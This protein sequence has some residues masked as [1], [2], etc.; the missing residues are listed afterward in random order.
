MRF[1]KESG[2]KGPNYT[3]NSVYN[4]RA[5]SLKKKYLS[6]EYK[7]RLFSSDKVWKVNLCEMWTWN[8]IYRLWKWS[9]GGHS[10]GLMICWKHIET[11]LNPGGKKKNLLIMHVLL[12][13][14]IFT[15]DD[16][17]WKTKQTSM[18]SHV[19]PRTYEKDPLFIFE[20]FCFACLILLL[21][22]IIRGF[23]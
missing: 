13:G 20:L 11:S 15:S 2:I 23:M 16:T 14:V 18:Y 22:K 5:N 1:C 4:S 17:R 12:I 6:S 9:L 3:R 8:Y 21:F 19:Y 10:Y 7:K